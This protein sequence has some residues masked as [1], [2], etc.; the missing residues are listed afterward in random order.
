MK[1]GRNSD[2]KRGA[3]RP[4]LS[5][6]LAALLVL[7]CGPLQVAQVYAEEVAEQQLMDGLTGGG[8][9]A[10][11]E[12]DASQPDESQEAAAAA[13]QQK[14]VSA[15]TSDS[16]AA[17][18]TRAAEDTKTA[19]TSSSG[20]ANA[21][22]SSKESKA[23]DDSK[24]QDAADASDAQ[25]GASSDKASADASAQDKTASIPKTDE[26]DQQRAELLK[27]DG[28]VAVTLQGDA[29]T[30]QDAAYKALKSD[31]R[32]SDKTA[33]SA[34]KTAFDLQDIDMEPAVRDGDE[35]PT[36]EGDPGSG[37]GSFVDTLQLRWI[38]KDDDP[39]NGDDALLYLHPFDNTDQSVRMRVSYALSGSYDYGPG[40]VTI[41][42]PVNIFKDRDG[43]PVGS[44]RLA[45]PENPS[46]NGAWNYQRVGD[47]FV[48]TNTRRMSAASQGYIEFAIEGIT[49]RRVV[50]MAESDPF[51]AKIEVVTE[52]GNVIGATSNQITAQIDT[53]AKLTSA[54]KR[55]YSDPE[56]VTADQIP[57][58][59]RVE[60]VDRYVLVTWYMNGY[61]N[62]NTN[63]NHT[64]ELTDT[65]KD[66]YDGFILD[67][68][69]DA[70]THEQH[71]VIYKDGFD[72]STTKYT[73]V[74]T[75]YPITDQ[76]EEGKTY[77]FTNEVTYTLTETDPAITDRVTG[78]TDEQV[79]TTATD[80]ASVSWTY[81]KPEVLEPEGH[82]M[83]YK[84]GNSNKPY[85]GD[86]DGMQTIR[87]TVGSI[88]SDTPASGEAPYTGYFGNYPSALNGIRK[89]DDQLVSYTLNTIGYLLPWTYVENSVKTPEGG[90]PLGLLGNYGQK[91]VTMTTEDTGLS[92]DG[93]QLELG[94]DYQYTSVDFA[95]TPVIKKAVAINLNEDGS[96]SFESPSDGTVDYEK[97]DDSANI[98]PIE[99]QIKRNGSDEWETWATASWTSGS[100]VVTL[101]NGSTQTKSVVAL[102]EDTTAVRTQVT[103]TN[104]AVC[105]FV[106][107]NT[108]LLHDGALGPATDEAFQN[109]LNPVIEVDNT[110]TMVA[111]S[112]ANANKDD[113]T[114]IATFEKTGMDR[115]M[116]YTADT[117][118][119]I[120]KTG[121]QTDEDPDARQVTVHY[122][123]EVSVESFITDRETYEQALA[124]GEVTA[125]R[126]G[127]W[128]DLL[129]KGMVPQ[130]DTVK[131]RDG[132]AVR[133]MYTIEDY[134]GSG[135]TLLVVSADLTPVTSRRE[136]GD[137]S[138]YK[139]VITIAFD[140]TYSYESL[141][142]YGAEPHNVVAYMSD[143]KELG[144]V[145]DYRGEA[146]DSY[147][148]NHVNTDHAFASDEERDA[149][150]DLDPVR[151][152][153]NTVYAGATTRIDILE[154][155]TTD[156]TKRVMVNNDGRWSNGIEGR[157]DDSA[158]KWLADE[159][160]ARDVY[161]GGR[162]SYRLS[163]GSGTD[164]QTSQIVLYDT[165]ENFLPEESNF[166]PDDV[167]DAD[168]GN[169]WHGTFDGLDLSAL[170]VMGCA[171]KVYYST[172]DKLMLDQF[173]P[174][175]PDGGNEPM[176]E[177]LL[178]KEDG[179]LNSDVWQLLTDK[180][181]LAT[182][183]AIA[184]DASK[185]KDG[186]DFVLQPEETVAVYVN[187]RAPSGK[188]PHAVAHRQRL[189]ERGRRGQ[190]HPPGL[191][192]GW[193]RGLQ[194]LGL[195][196]L[197]RCRQPGRCTA[198]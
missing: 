74:K 24:K 189:H 19:K 12:A 179:S 89:D 27:T 61:I 39:D 148:K 88:Y 70:E 139:D 136:T 8:D 152:D 138:Y 64:L 141:E 182:V 60:G 18:D 21:K 15:K 162:Y 69:G 68:S 84:Y 14:E 161:V 65:K 169:V 75:A 45:V 42:I 91:P 142:S 36:G 71:I 128:Y 176:K 78:K 72:V 48:I 100:L 181:D 125:E 112:Y 133:Q 11:Q 33:K 81:R 185:A 76:F 154:E 118:V 23:Q 143:N 170:E 54:T 98:P 59:Q 1:N 47:T 197:G 3:I 67:S 156:L 116:G 129:P 123:S 63:Q 164:T 85:A 77:T 40:E 115:L 97:D 140:A 86:A 168:T 120:K 188:R 49:P 10:A 149:M 93:K 4:L 41:T 198:G 131:L 147:G 158:N 9:N 113:P 130:L 58:N 56:I 160:Q 102:P 87:P 83:L 166:D 186:S 20:D 191:Y 111:T 52:T 105:Y 195:K 51:Q 146:D 2:R 155:A 172:Q 101:A 28:L 43:N 163:M 44:M 107:V 46:T 110:A 32:V 30:S 192:Q 190:V 79:K 82:F 144:T 109:S 117:R 37:S 106:R 53:F 151:A 80:T 108:T 6:L 132:D 114:T 31:V 17:E 103:A 180:T 126:G 99:L 121:K 177:N 25:K 165:L 183:K 13:D 175:N 184:I 173:T 104:A 157:W 178:F 159:S 7:Q 196:G 187:M 94:K 95:A 62:P 66:N 119:N 96:V 145:D 135:R 153:P 90:N 193:S 124:D 150:N 26:K 55:A 122:E 34:A 73:T 5:I 92:M 194:A 16:K 134:K 50:D 22:T 171:P 174:E 57:E 167:E 38:T 35:L 127:T 137:V 29:T